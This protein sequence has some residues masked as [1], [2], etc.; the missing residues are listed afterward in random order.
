MRGLLKMIFFLFILF[1]PISISADDPFTV[2]QTY[3]DGVNSYEILS[4]E[5]LYEPNLT[6]PD[7]FG[8]LPDPQDLD[9]VVS[10]DGAKD[11]GG[12]G[13]VASDCRFQ[14]DQ[15][16]NKL[17]LRGED[18]EC[19]NPSAAAELPSII[20]KELPSVASEQKPRCNE[21]EEHLCCKGNEISFWNGFRSIVSQCTKCQI[22]PSFFTLVM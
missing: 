2:D 17:R 21:G 19:K 11:S 18:E 10:L 6:S 5:F 9:Y 8:N 13:P 14:N 22:S 7:L 16:I 4:D 1:T 15:R 20:I 3:V 12:L